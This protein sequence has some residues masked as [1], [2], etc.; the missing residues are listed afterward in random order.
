MTTTV[1]IFPRVLSPV[2]LLNRSEA[3]AMKLSRRRDRK[4]PSVDCQ[5][6]KVAPVI[7]TAHAAMKN[8]RP[9]FWTLSSAIMVSKALA[10]VLF[11]LL[12]PI[13]RVLKTCPSPHAERALDS[14]PLMCQG[15]PLPAHEHDRSAVSR[16]RFVPIF[17]PSPSLGADLSHAGGYKQCLPASGFA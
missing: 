17:G 16:S 5:R 9:T 12:R 1:T 4:I 11:L 3:N 14:N 7:R 15:I 10:W 8:A 2:F 13:S 6:D